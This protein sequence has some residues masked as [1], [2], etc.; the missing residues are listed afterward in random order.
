LFLLFFF[1]S[2]ICTANVNPSE[3]SKFI[4][5][6]NRTLTNWNN[7]I[8]SISDLPNGYTAEDADFVQYDQFISKY[9]QLLL[10]VNKTIDEGY[11]SIGQ[12]AYDAIDAFVNLNSGPQAAGSCAK[13]VIKIEQE[14]V[15]TRT[16]FLATLEINNDGNI[17][18]YLFSFEEN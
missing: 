10:E 8:L 2:T 16:G 4:A 6:W 18:L 3:A 7:G 14:L 11:D 9:E 17:T 1:V 13:V 12:A 15:L 5:R